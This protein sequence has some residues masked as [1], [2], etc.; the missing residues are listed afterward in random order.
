MK[1]SLCT[2]N[3]NQLIKY[4]VCSKMILRLRKKTKGKIFILLCKIKN[5]K[6]ELITGEQFKW[7]DKR[8]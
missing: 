1:Y 4:L 8:T 3:T 6:K 5:N 2:I 7:L